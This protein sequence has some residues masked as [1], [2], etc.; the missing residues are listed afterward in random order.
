MFQPIEAANFSVHA[1]VSLYHQDNWVQFRHSEFALALGKLARLLV[2]RVVAEGEE[3]I[4]DARCSYKLRELDG[5]FS[6][7]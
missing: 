3:C 1:R 6:W 2:L 4:R 7:C 5:N